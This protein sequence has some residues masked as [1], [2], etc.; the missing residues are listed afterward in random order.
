MEDTSNAMTFVRVSYKKN[1]LKFPLKIEGVD[2]AVGIIA[3]THESKIQKM[4]DCYLSLM[5]D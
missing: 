2:T 3:A 5:V 4:N 1:Q